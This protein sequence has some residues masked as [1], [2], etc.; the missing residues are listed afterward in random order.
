VR[1]K[2]IRPNWDAKEKK[3][4]G[5]GKGRKR[6]QKIRREKPLPC[7][8]RRVKSTKT[9]REPISG[10]ISRAGADG[11][12]KEKEKYPKKWNPMKER[13]KKTTFRLNCFWLTKE[14]HTGR[15]SLG[16]YKAK[17]GEGS[18]GQRGGASIITKKKKKWAPRDQ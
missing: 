12:R 6:L 9:R 14:P 13:G 15:G 17:E 8:S 1:R 4:K 11:G 7:R 10:K 2:K 18:E 3:V 5:S 16:K